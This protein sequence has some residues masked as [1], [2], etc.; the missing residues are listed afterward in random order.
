MKHHTL[1]LESSVL[2]RVLCCCI[3]AGLAVAWA[4]TTLAADS[5][6]DKDANASK[7][8]TFPTVVV[9]ANF[10]QSPLIT[11]L[12]P[13]APQQPI[14]ASDGAD[15]LKTVPG[16]SVMRKGGSNGDPVFRGMAGS[17]L[18]IV[19]DGTQLAGGCPARMDPPTAY[20]SPALYDKVTI[21]KGPESVIYGPVGSAGTVLFQRDTPHYLE[22]AA[23]LDAS[24]TVG[25]FGR[26]DQTVDFKGG[27][28]QFYVDVDGNRTH[29]DDYEDGH[30]D[31]VHSLY[32][33][34]N[35]NTAIGWTPDPDTLL[36]LSAG[37]GNGK[38]AY[39]FS[40][41]DGVKFL[42]Q[43]TALRFEKKHLTET[44]S[45]L[46]A[47]VY[48]NDIDH[49]MDNY[50]L[51]RPDPNSSMPMAMASD[52]QRDTT[53][54]RIAATFDWED[55]D[56]VVGADA[57]TSTHNVR[58]GGPEGSSM[59]YYKALSRVR[60]AR[61][62]DQGAF[63]QATWTMTERDRLI[64]GTRL[65]RASV[66]GYGVAMSDGD[67]GMSM[68]S[69]DGGMSM[70]M[71]SESATADVDRH[72][73]LP[74]G[75]VRYEHDL[76]MP[77]TFYAGLGHA[78]RF[79][80][81]WELFG[82]HVN[83]TIASFADLRPERTTQLDI[84]L[85]YH[86][87]RLKAWI[88]GYAGVIDDYILIHYGMTSGYASNIDAHVAG[89]EAGAEYRLG[90]DWKASATL[91]YAWGE[92]TTEHRPLP[93]MPPLETRLGL[94]WD[95]GTWS[96]GALWR[97]VENQGRVAVGEGNIVGQDL[98]KTGGFGVFSV[99][100]GWRI[101]REWSLTAGVDNL[102]DKAYAEHISP[103][104]VELQG[105][106]TST[107]VNEPGRVAWMKLALSF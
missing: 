47:K 103:S 34:W 93:Q 2:H 61:M 94:D 72:A 105:F 21:V 24:A 65:D 56:L 39:A 76:Q 68:G 84:G 17:R 66:R 16:F 6:Y 85:Q 22:P 99:H 50:T 60:D 48:R 107:R 11:V 101:D 69:M 80:D 4:S 19:S 25:S 40:G 67:S 91:A 44:W 29:S 51:R 49:V 9:T 102:F 43:S 79:P 28:P 86:S 32:N 78:E 27:T 77:A 5:T 82:Q 104:V 35:V 8:K 31:K 106:T 26:N 10:Q 81:Y 90:N 59:G 63:A 88:S 53:G 73:T 74:S 33:R 30:G 45:K 98:G 13:K 71:G 7:V 58:N 38:A 20:I 100:G 97:V 3:A 1:D 46:E 54:G 62:E 92:D 14:P 12:D 75:F 42:R 52:L 70:G 95:N 23:S 87:E 18:A 41:M 96:A 37:T 64:A 15:L 57:S 83:T 55:L 89:G 36:E